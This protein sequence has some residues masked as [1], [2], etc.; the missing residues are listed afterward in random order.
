VVAGVGLSQLGDQSPFIAGATN[1]AT[2]PDIPDGA[3]DVAVDT[4]FA[5]GLSFRYDYPDSPWTSE[6]GW[7]YRSNDSE[8]TLADGTDLPG[9][10]YASNTFYLN[11]RYTFKSGRLLTPWVG[12]GLTWLQE[13]DLDSESGNA[14]RSFS[15]GG[16]VGFQVMAGAD[17]DIND[18]LYL[19]S[20]LRYSSQRDLSLSEE[21]GA[22]G[23]VSEI[24]YQPFTVG[25]GL[26]VRF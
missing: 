6:F 21:G 19:T 1:D 2:L 8:I 4:G 12:A 9:G 20:E 22:A 15:D 5:A 14:E 11:G 17:Y 23:V 3:I 18:R 24:D 10:N 13:V 7:E 16:S 25:I 26:G